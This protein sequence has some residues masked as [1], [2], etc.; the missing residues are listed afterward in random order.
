MA[1]M[2]RHAN[3][4]LRDSMVQTVSLLACV[5]MAC[6]TVKMGTVIAML[7]I[8]VWLATKHVIAITSENPVEILAPVVM[9]V[10]AIDSMEVAC[11]LLAGLVMTV[12]Q[13]V[14]NHSLAGVVC[15]RVGVKMGRP[16]F[17][18]M[19]CVSVRPATRETSATHRVRRVVGVP[20]VP[21]T[22]LVKTEQ[23][24]LLKRGSV[25]VHQAIREQTV[26]SNATPVHSAKTVLT[27][28]IVSMELRVI[29]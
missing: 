19:V 23:H 6:V 21:T 15:L 9:V 11:V 20:I 10:S 12:A 17:T 8:W 5:I 14:L 22:V 26:R 4:V 7:D 3:R 1:V 16:V 24:V 2:K 13:S 29:T 25:T 27:L 28:V 18:W